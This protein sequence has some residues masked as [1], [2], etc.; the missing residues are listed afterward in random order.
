MESSSN[1]SRII[2]ALKA[3]ENRKGVSVR[4]IAK[5]YNVP[6]AT[7][8]HRYTGRHPR[9]NIITNSRKLTDLE[10]QVLIQYI[11]SLA[12]EGFPPQVSVVEDMAN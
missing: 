11:L 12:A 10:E 8:W 6:E 9:H 5:T 2:L 3:L 4:S 7:L 1:E